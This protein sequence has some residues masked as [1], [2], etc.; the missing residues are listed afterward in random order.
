MPDIGVWGPP[1]LSSQRTATHRRI[2][3]GGF[4]TY[5]PGGK[6]INGALSRDSGNTGDLDTLRPGLL[7]GKITATGLYAPVVLGV[8]TGAYT[9]GGTEITVSAAQAVE[10]VRRVGATGNVYVIG[11][12]TAAGTVAVSASKAYSEVNT[13]TGAIT[14]EDIGA[15]KIA[16][17]WVVATDGTHIPRTFIPEDTWGIRVTDIDG[18][19][20]N[21]D[22]A[23]VPVAAIID[24]SQLLYWP[25]DTSMQAWV[26]D[27][28]NDVAG[29]KFVFDDAF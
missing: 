26:K 4:Y 16:G 5:L 21:A 1:G 17:S 3:H 27:Q 11:P 25:S 9:S 29:C 12:P 18:N 13:S 24:S 22:F 15:N 10:I 7:M 19:N 28:L 14:I 20:V 6:T 2:L 8:T 23:K